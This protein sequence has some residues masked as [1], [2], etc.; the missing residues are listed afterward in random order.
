MIAGKPGKNNQAM[1]IPQ[2]PAAMRSKR[3]VMGF[4]FNPEANS[5][6]SSDFGSREDK[7]RAESTV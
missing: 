6:Y 4:M 2:T 7:E 1:T 3:K 5:L